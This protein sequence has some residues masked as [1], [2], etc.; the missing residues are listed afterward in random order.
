MCGTGESCGVYLLHED[1]VTAAIKA[2]TN[3]VSEL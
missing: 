3:Q 2:S 1:Y